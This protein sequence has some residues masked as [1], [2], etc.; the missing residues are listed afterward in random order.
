MRRKEAEGRLDAYIDIGLL[1]VVF[2]VVVA[3]A[4]DP[5]GNHR[6]QQPVAWMLETSLDMDTTSA[7][8]LDCRSFRNRE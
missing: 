4:I 8:N 3:S 1:I 5:Y 7:S 6:R 2:A